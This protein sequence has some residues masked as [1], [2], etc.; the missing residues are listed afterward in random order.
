MKKSAIISIIL[1]VLII[2][3]G[4]ITMKVGADKAE[5]EGVKL[6]RQTVTDSGN[7][8]EK[9]EIEDETINKISVLMNDCDVRIIGGAEKTC[10]EVINFHALMYTAY[11]SGGSLI[12]ENDLFNTVTN[13]IVNN[14][15]KFNGFRDYFRFSRHN[16][17]KVI[18]VFVSDDM[19]VNYIEVS[20]QN[21][22]IDINGIKSPADYVVKIENGDLSVK[23][24]PIASK[25]NINVEKGDVELDKISAYSISA[26]V[27]EGEIRYSKPSGVL[28]TDYDLTCVLGKV[29]FNGTDSGS[30][31]R[32]EITDTSPVFVKCKVGSGDIRIEETFD[33]GAPAKVPDVTETQEETSEATETPAVTP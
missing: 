7:L 31:V 19:P 25:I 14:D 29:Y 15:V 23:N 4:A 12:V 9:V 3:A 5:E 21:G 20:I 2:V 17:K 18:N 13:Q 24:V 8:V 26:D 27:K 33:P 1:S 28:V 30:F 11:T 22:R 6:F 16:D 10:V 32:S